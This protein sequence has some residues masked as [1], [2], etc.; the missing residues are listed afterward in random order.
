MKQLSLY[1]GQE[2]TQHSNTREKKNKNK[3]GELMITPT[4]FLKSTLGSRL[5]RRNRPHDYL[6]I[7]ETKFRIWGSKLIEFTTQSTKEERASY[8]SLQRPIECSA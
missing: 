1:I 3:K 5:G 7:K 2:E 8:T 4:C 6:C